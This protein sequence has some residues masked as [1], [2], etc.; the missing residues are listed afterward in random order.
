MHDVHLMVGMMLFQTVTQY[1]CSFWIV[2]VHT[3]STDEGFTRKVLTLDT[4]VASDIGIE[5]RWWKTS[6]DRSHFVKF[7]TDSSFVSLAHQSQNRSDI[8]SDASL[9]TA[10]GRRAGRMKCK[11]INVTFLR[12]Q[13]SKTKRSRE[14]I[15]PIL[16]NS[17][18]RNDPDEGIRE[19]FSLLSASE[20]GVET[21]P[22]IATG[23]WKWQKRKRE[24]SASLI[25]KRERRRKRK[26]SFTLNID[27]RSIQLGIGQHFFSSI[28]K[29]IVRPPSERPDSDDRMI[30]AS[31]SSQTINSR[32]RDSSSTNSDCRLVVRF[33]VI[34][35]RSQ[36]KTDEIER[37]GLCIESVSSHVSSTCS[38]VL[39]CRVCW[40]ERSSAK[41]WRQWSQ[42]SLKQQEIKLVTKEKWI[43]ARLPPPTL[44][45][46]TDQASFPGERIGVSSE[47]CQLMNEGTYCSSAMN[48]HRSGRGRKFFG[49]LRSILTRRTGFSSSTTEIDSSCFICFHL[50]CFRLISCL[51]RYCSLTQSEQDVSLLGCRTVFAIF[52]S[53]RSASVT[54]D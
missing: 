29:K 38:T 25:E 32:K 20:Q 17:C 21:K 51:A 5:Q 50:S 28:V 30:T 48:N 46:L 47:C 4:I 13:P 49:N 39:A 40:D 36:R 12:D 9:H 24:R 15:A 6:G 53:S 26:V 41:R 3:Q 18:E 7:L 45:N 1:R 27:R 35:F 31:E 37:E 16:A 34:H 22:N 8:E 10:L 52:P 2:V 23:D 44:E 43:S 42:P 14:N 11:Q 19:P 54:F 33:G